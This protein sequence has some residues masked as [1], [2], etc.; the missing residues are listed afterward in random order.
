LNSETILKSNGKGIAEEL[1]S[2]KSEIIIF[3]S[4]QITLYLLPYLETNSD[5][6]SIS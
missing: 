3:F 5:L 6:V 4:T 1:V 2:S